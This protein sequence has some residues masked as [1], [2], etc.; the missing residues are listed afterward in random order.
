MIVTWIKHWLIT[1]LM[2]V[3]MINTFIRALQPVQQNSLL[4]LDS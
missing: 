4:S 2:K 3:L 1:I